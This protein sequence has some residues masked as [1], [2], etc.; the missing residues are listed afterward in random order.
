VTEAVGALCGCRVGVLAVTSW[1]E[2]DASSTGV[3]G[4]PAFA[5]A[6]RAIAVGR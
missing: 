2:T 1:G 4:E 6:V 5:R 3:L